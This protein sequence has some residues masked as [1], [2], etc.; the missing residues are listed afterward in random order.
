MFVGGL[1]LVDGHVNLGN[2]GEGGDETEDIGPEKLTNKTVA[3][4]FD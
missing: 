4:T 3:K 1:L 2:E